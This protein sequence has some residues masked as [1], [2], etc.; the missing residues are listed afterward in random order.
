M[1]LDVQKGIRYFRTPFMQE[2]VLLLFQ[3]LVLIASSI[4]QLNI[5]WLAIG[6]KQFVFSIYSS[7]CD[8]FH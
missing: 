4:E 3:K 7:W 8:R 2:S 6:N 1:A 5:E